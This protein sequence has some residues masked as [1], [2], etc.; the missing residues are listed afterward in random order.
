M[1]QMLT[2][3]LVTSL[4]PI[5]YTFICKSSE[6]FVAL[7]HKIYTLQNRLLLSRDKEHWSKFA[8]I[9]LNSALIIKI[10]TMC[11]ET[12]SISYLYTEPQT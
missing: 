7:F 1:E 12:Q 10:S 5:V 8:A 11:L 6:I 3:N 9:V 4:K 2:Q